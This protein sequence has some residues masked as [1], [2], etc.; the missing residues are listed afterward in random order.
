MIFST[1]DENQFY[2]LVRKPSITI[3]LPFESSADCRSYA[4][5]LLLCSTSASRSPSHGTQTPRKTPGN[6]VIADV[7]DEVS[8]SSPHSPHSDSSDNSC[9][10]CCYYCCYYCCFWCCC[11]ESQSTRSSYKLR[12]CAALR[13][14]LRP[15]ST[16]VGHGIH[17]GRCSS[18]PVAEAGVA[19]ELGRQRCIE[20]S[21]IQ[22]RFFHAP[23]R[24]RSFAHD[25]VVRSRRRRRRRRG[26]EEQK[27]QSQ[28]MAYVC[29]R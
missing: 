7:V 2:N 5:L 27:A 28:R 6:L 4:Q 9:R 25:V 16:R 1:G 20:N 10:H 8:C 12:R 11:L 15:Q 18:R 22:A 19:V 21:R 29:G 26:G 23:S 24:E 3:E 17:P 14:A 13:L